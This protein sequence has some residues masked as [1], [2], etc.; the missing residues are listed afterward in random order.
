MTSLNAIADAP[1]LTMSGVFVEA[2]SS[3][4]DDCNVVD[5]AIEEVV[6]DSSECL[7]NST[8]FATASSIK[9]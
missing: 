4:A 9:S 7:S 5:D 8:M 1:Y 3:S 2:N 6:V